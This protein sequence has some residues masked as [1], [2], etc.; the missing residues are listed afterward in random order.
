MTFIATPS[1]D[2]QVLKSIHS[3]H[4]NRIENVLTSQE[5]F[6]LCILKFGSKGTSQ[7]WSGV[8]QKL[9]KNIYNFTIKYLN[10][11]L[12]TRKNLCKWSITQSSASS[13]CLQSES[14]QH[15]VSAATNYLKHGRYTWRH[16][17]VLLYLAKT[18][19]TLRNSSHYADLP[20]FLSPSLIAGDS[21]RP[22]IVF[23]TED[24]T[25]LH[26][27]AYYWVRKQH[28]RKQYSKS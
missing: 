6:I 24:P 2:Q 4:E 25:P 27:R 21:Y 12:A 23:V 17:S 5:F 3:E 9:P 8:Q 11:T 20:S 14:L 22:D 13:F 28:R 7:L 18:L 26:G 19:S 15:I 16:H 1:K 10:N